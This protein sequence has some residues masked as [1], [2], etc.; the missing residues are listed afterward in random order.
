MK[1]IKYLSI[2]VIAAT[3]ASLG[4]LNAQPGEKNEQGMPSKDY[5]MGKEHSHKSFIPNL[6]EEQKGKIKDLRLAHF[7]ETQPLKNQLGELKARK[8]TLATA[9]KPDLKLIDANI[10]EISKIQNQLMKSRAQFQTQIR[11]LLTDEQKMA[12]DMHSSGEMRHKKG[13]FHK[14][15]HSV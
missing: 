1:T 9:E 3:L 13:A 7:K 2:A 12:F 5:K 15:E 14:R 10:D 8:K 11:A 6:T 4:S